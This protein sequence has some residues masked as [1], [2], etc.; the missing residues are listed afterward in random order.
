MERAVFHCLPQDTP[1]E[2][3]NLKGFVSSFNVI[4]GTD[5]KWT[6]CLDVQGKQSGSPAQPIPQPE[7]LL[8]ACGQT[9]IVI[10][11]KNIVWPK[12]YQCDHVKEHNLLKTVARQIGKPFEDSVYELAFPAEPLKEKTDSEVAAIAGQIAHVILS[13]SKKAKTRGGISD[14]NPFPWTFRLVTSDEID[15]PEITTGIRSYVSESWDLFESPED[16]LKTRSEALAGFSQE[17]HLQAS[18]AVKKFEGYTGFLRLLVV[19][20]FGEGESL[21]DEDITE[22][23]KRAK[24][25]GKIDQVWLTGREWVSLDDY[26]LAWERIR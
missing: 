5:Y 18:K 4:C 20:F 23:V 6:K 24:L 26:E 3:F 17:Y 22:I 1:C 8:E 2:K 14:G 11:H 9:P 7:G 21:L 15:D 25:L 19:Q 13:N 10:E 12:K 16:F